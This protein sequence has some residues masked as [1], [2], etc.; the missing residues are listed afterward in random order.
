MTHLVP[1][2]FLEGPVDAEEGHMVSLAGDEFL[3]HG[4]HLVSA[5]RGVAEH[6]VHRQQRDDGQNLLCAGKLWGDQDG[7]QGQR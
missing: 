7:L 5:G 4:E 1:T 2:D 6:G 3:A